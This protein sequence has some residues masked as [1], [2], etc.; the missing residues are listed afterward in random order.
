VQSGWVQDN[1]HGPH[2]DE[3]ALAA[4]AIQPTS[5]PF[6][7]LERVAAVAAIEGLNCARIGRFLNSEE[8]VAGRVVLKARDAPGTHD[9]DHFE[10]LRPNDD[11]EVC[12]VLNTLPT[13]PRLA[14]L[15]SVPSGKGQRT[16][17]GEDSAG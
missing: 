11:R 7:L 5:D 10:L 6:S 14:L 3:I 13:G 12:L 17:T 2:A 4:Q 8:P 16:V 15:A 9:S 1:P